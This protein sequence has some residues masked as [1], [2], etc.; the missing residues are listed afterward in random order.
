MN[1]DIITIIMVLHSKL[2]T[3]FSVSEHKQR[4][5]DLKSLYGSIENTVIAQ[6][7]YT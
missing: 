3:E 4:K 1:D 2:R 6:H 5:E 7:A